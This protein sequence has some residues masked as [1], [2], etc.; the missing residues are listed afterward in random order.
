MHEAPA[1]AQE[2]AAIALISPALAVGLELAKRGDREL[3]Y[4]R[5]SFTHGT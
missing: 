5:A 4:S 1:E 2:R 3:D